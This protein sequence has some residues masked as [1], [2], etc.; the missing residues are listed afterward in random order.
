VDPVQGT[1]VLIDLRLSLRWLKRSPTLALAAVCTLA[2]AVAATVAVFAVVDKVLIR[3]LPIRDAHRVVVMWPREGATP[4]TIAEVSYA[5]FRSWQRDARGFQQLA[6]V[7]STNW[8]L[9]LEEGEPASIPVAA[10]SASFF[11]LVGA[12]AMIGRTLQPEDDRPGSE[13]VAVLSFGSWQRRFGGDPA[14]VGRSLR[15]RDGP[16]TVVGIMPEGF[17]YPRGAEMWV[18]VVPQLQ[19]AS[20]QWGVDV[21]NDPGFGVLFVLGRLLPSVTIESARA[22]ISNLI[23][24]DA[25]TAFRAGMEAVLTPLDEYLLGNTRTALLALM[26]CVGLVL[27]IAWSNVTVLLLVRAATR[28]HEAATRIAIGASRWRIVRQSVADACAVSAL[29]GLAGFAL[30]GWTVQALVAIAPDNLPRLDLVR[31]DGRTLTFAVS[32]TLLTALVVGIVPGLQMSHRGTTGALAGAVSRVARSHRLRRAVSVVQVGLA[33]VLLICAGLVGRSFVNLMKI[34]IGFRP[35]R[36]LTLDVQIPDASTER[37]EAFFA[38]L[39]ERVRALPGVEAAGAVYQRPLE[40][41]GIGMDGTVV[42]EGQ[43][44]DL[45]FRDWERNPRVN[46]ESATV[47]YFEAIGLPIVRGRAFEATDVARAP[48]V[49][50]VGERLAQRLWP[51]QDPIGR[52]LSVPGMRPDTRPASPWATVVGVARDARYRGLTDPRFDLY[53]PEAQS[54]L[55]VKHVMVRATGDPVALGAAVRAEARRLDP[56]VLVENLAALG[57]VVRQATAP[58][59]FSVSTL[60]LLSVVALALAVLGVYATVSQTVVERRV[61]I[62]IR[63]AVGAVPSQVAG[64]VLREGVRLAVAGIALGVAVAAMMSRALAGLLYEVRPLDPLTSV[65]AALLFFAVAVTALALPASKAARTE[66]GSVLKQ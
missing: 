48:R 3:P 2:V 14:V 11:P 20:T 53:L 38:A 22:G 54:D 44:T 27:A 13:R 32:I 25:P 51:G 45:Q 62:A 65:T 43:R 46:L 21:L 34:D 37:H 36:V 41:A 60:G 18:P 17:G 9:L 61:E 12:R 31:V 4:T 58:W 5:T 29:G 19:A 33:L 66:P 52:R 6:A 56:T 23:A 49:A 10:V 64:L 55:R 57:H 1:R 50:I 7:G 28:A 30:G 63:V 15:F 39:I 8:T 35:E 24:R 42:I 59:R 16:Y 47:G 26:L 40:H